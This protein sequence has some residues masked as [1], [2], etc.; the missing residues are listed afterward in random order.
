VHFYAV[1]GNLHNTF[2]VSNKCPASLGGH[3][4]EEH[5]DYDVP[6]SLGSV[7]KISIE[8]HKWNGDTNNPDPGWSVPIFSGTF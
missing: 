7:N 1:S 3:A 8:G 2:T 4:H 6:G 5:Y